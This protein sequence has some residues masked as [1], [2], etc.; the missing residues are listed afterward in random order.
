[1]PDVG[2]VVAGQIHAYFQDPERR[3]A[4]ADLLAVGIHWPAPTVAPAAG[5][6]TG[7]TWVLTGALDAMPRD[8]ARDRL[9]R[10][11]ASVTDSVS[12]KT[13]RVVAGPGAGSKLDR[14]QKLGIPVLDEAALLALLA[15]LEPGAQA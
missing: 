11:G 14:A 13:T 12:K 10:L 6:L 4:I 5:P 1:M 15:D 2:P 3:A 9:R 8:V 7:E